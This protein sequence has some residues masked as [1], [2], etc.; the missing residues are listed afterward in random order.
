MFQSCAIERGRIKRNRIRKTS[1][2]EYQKQLNGDLF[3]SF[4]VL[5]PRK[6]LKGSLGSSIYYAADFDKRGYSHFLA[7]YAYNEKNFI[8]EN[9]SLKNKSMFDLSYALNLGNMFDINEDISGILTEQKDT[10]KV[11]NPIRCFT[12]MLYPISIDGFSLYILEK[13]TGETFSDYGQQLTGMQ[14][15]EFNYIYGV[16]V[17]KNNTEIIYWSLIY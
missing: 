1:F 9:I 7:I 12:N 14:R 11:V 2:N 3:K 13:G 16:Y 6:N 15:R 10:I 8:K 17:S 4:F 5:F